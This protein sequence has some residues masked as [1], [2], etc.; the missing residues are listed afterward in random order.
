MRIKNKKNKIKNPKAIDNLP[1]LKRRTD[2]PIADLKTLTRYSLNKMR[3]SGISMNYNEILTLYKHFVSIFYQDL[4][5]G[6]IEI[7]KLGKFCKRGNEFSIIL[8]EKIQELILSNL[9]SRTYNEND[10]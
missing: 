6:D 7:D 10:E 1:K 8:D 9:E 5:E 2:K 3:K 4:C